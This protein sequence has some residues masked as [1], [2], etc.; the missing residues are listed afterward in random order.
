MP[1]KANNVLVNTYGS[2]YVSKYNNNLSREDFAI[3]I[4]SIDL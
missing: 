3:T 2:V 4:L 1:F